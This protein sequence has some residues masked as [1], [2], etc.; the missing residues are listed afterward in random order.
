MHLERSDNRPPSMLEPH[1]VNRDM[2]L[3][4]ALVAVA[5]H[6]GLPALVVLVTSILAATVASGEKPDFIE[7]HVVEARFVRLGKKPDPK[8]LPNRIVPRK[9]TAP[10]ESTVVS[11]NLNP[12]K[13]DKRDAGPR[14]DNPTPDLLTRIG[15]RAQAFAEIAEEREK[16]G[17]PDGIPEGTE[18]EA[19]EGDIYLGKLVSFIKRGWTIPTTLG[20]TH[21][22]L[23]IASFEITR[24]LK[25]G[26]SKID[27]SSGQPLFDQSIEDRFQQLRASS[28]TLPDPPPEVAYRFLGKTIGVR[29]S[30]EG[31][32]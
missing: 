32:Q 24:D 5:A 11:K 8:K 14:P 10:D 1:Y 4:G 17:D 7:E 13:P 23:A 27:K 28:A 2:A 19:K 16:E 29:F 18:T 22:L 30:G 15:D 31:A 25:V 3:G 20:D 9:S 6:I 12:E 26:V 21:K